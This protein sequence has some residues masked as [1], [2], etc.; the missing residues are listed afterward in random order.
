[1]DEQGRRSLTG[2]VLA[3]W[4]LG[5]GMSG[6]VFGAIRWRNN[7]VDRL[8]YSTLGLAALT[9]PMLFVDSLWT[10]TLVLFISG[11]AISPALVSGY[12][13]VERLVIDSRITEAISWS[14]TGLIIGS[15]AMAALAGRLIDLWG[16]ERSFVLAVAPPVV[17]AVIVLLI[18]PRLAARTAF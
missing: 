2:V 15:A 4:A 3:C 1:M 12:A 7:V 6:L 14:I 11:W 16:A 17:T 5:S 9:L 10:F 18:R 8:L 13:I